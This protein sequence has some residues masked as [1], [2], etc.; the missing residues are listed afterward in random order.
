MALQK[1]VHVLRNT[2]RKSAV[3]SDT[4]P[5]GKQK[6]CGILVLEQK[7]NL[8]NEDEC[9]LSFRSVLRD[10]VENRVEDYK[11]T[12]R[13]KLLAEVENVIADQLLN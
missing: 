2:G 8:I 3:L 13:H 5:Q 10:T 1:V 4:L 12:D 11:H 9:F 6:V 7:V